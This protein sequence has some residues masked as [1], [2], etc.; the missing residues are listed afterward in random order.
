MS[1]AEQV[2]RTL[3]TCAVDDGMPLDFLR[4]L[5]TANPARV[6][7]LSGKGRLEPGRDADLLV[8]RRETWEIV[9]VIAKGRRLVRDGEI[10]KREG[11]LA[12]SDRVLALQG[13]R[14]DGGE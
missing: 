11:F 1:I 6:L 10:V 12:S 3:R 5:V 7:K 9:E 4:P 8:I 2:F 13:E 14:A